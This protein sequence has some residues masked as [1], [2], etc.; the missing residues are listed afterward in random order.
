MVQTRRAKWKLTW[1][2]LY[3][4]F[5]MDELNEFPKTVWHP[6]PPAQPSAINNL[7]ASSRLD[8]PANYLDL[9]NF[10]NGGEGELSVFPGWFSL[11]PAEEVVQL[12]EGYEV[13][14]WLPGFFG[15]GSSG[16]GEMLAFDTRTQQPWKIYSV[17]FVGMAEEEAVLVAESF[18]TFIKATDI[19]FPENS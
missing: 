5:P 8:L 12:N 2:T 1:L 15:F 18:A 19:V 3:Y 17:P 4:V 14:K 10:S 6:Q 7:L 11:W 9:L 13:Q 16:G